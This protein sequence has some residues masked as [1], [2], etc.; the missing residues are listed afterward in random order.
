[1]SDPFAGYPKPSVTSL[2]C[3]TQSACTDRAGFGYHS[4]TLGTGIYTTDIHGKNLCHGIYVLKGGGMAGD[5]G[6][7]T[8]STDPVTGD[9]CD[10]RVMIFNTLTNYPASGGTC[11]AM[12]VGGNHDITLYAMTTG[13]Y[14]G[15]LFFQ[16]PA[17]AATMTFG[18]TSFQLSA[19]GT[20]YLP[21][22]KF[23]A[24]GHPSITGGQIVAKTID[25]QNAILDIN[26]S[27]NTSAQPILPR[28]TK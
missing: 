28:L 27:P 2:A 16:D 15:L 26:Y 21:N 18:G 6:V 19:T 13:I 11:A 24:D 23:V 1:V 10:G 7:D 20:I 4:D 12:G 5:I 3:G 14:A 8:S 17:C 9:V 25:L 22:A